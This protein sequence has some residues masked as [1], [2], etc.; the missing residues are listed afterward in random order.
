[1]KRIALCASY[2]TIALSVF[3]I[4][5]MAEDS[6]GVDTSFGVDSSFG[7]DEMDDVTIRVVE[8]DDSSSAKVLSLPTNADA[9][10]VDRAE[11]REGRG[12][13][14]ANDMLVE[15][16]QG[17]SVDGLAEAI[18][19]ANE[20]AKEA[21]QNAMDAREMRNAAKEEHGM[22]GGSHGKSGDHKPN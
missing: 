9:H 13:S 12:L 16:K 18:S 22:A 19:V 4:P 10:A 8:E 2:L 20:H 21:L 5:A 17:G 1:M 15:H 11:S 7:V 3:S 14:K 6:F